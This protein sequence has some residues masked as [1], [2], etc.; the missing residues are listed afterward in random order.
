MAG[1][2]MRTMAFSKGE[3]LK[4]LITRASDN[5]VLAYDYGYRGYGYHY[6]YRHHYGYG[7]R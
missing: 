5:L 1:R 3:V 6:G 2:I 7:P 4:K